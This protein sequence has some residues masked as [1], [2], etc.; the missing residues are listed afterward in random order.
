VLERH[1]SAL[2]SSS[3]YGNNYMMKSTGDAKP[4]ITNS[5]TS[6]SEDQDLASDV[7]KISSICTSDAIYILWRHAKGLTISAGIFV[8]RQTYYVVS[9]NAMGIYSITGGRVW[10][11]RGRPQY[12]QNFGEYRRT[13]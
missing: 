2:K 13:Q 4:F 3:H 8:Y 7:R 9:S 5:V 6:A 10:D 11:D 1:P 12:D